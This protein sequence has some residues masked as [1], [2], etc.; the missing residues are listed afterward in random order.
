MTSKLQRKRNH[1]IFET[2]AIQ[3]KAKTKTKQAQK[4]R[5]VKSLKGK[6]ELRL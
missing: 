6:F 1:S 2:I 5:P 3:R 4:V